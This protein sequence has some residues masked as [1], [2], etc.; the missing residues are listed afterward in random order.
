M[1]TLSERQALIK[2]A[3]SAAKLEMDAR[4]KVLET[5]LATLTTSKAPAKK[6]KGVKGDE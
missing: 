4:L 3:V 6:K 1:L 5:T 2:D